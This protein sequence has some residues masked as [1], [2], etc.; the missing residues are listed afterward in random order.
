MVYEKAI[1]HVQSQWGIIKKPII[2]FVPFEVTINERL[3]TTYVKFTFLIVL[4][5][6]T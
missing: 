1:I 6:T 5:L 4:F 3:M 2:F